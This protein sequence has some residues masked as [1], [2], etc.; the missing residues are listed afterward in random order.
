[1]TVPERSR[2]V[3]FRKVFGKVSFM[4]QRTE[5]GDSKGPKPGGRRLHAA[6]TAAKV[7]TVTEPGR[8]FDGQGLFLLVE[9][10]GAKRWKQRLT[11]QGRRQELGLGPY[12]VVTLAMARE[13]AIQ[14]RRDV[15]AGENP[16]TQRLRERDVPTFAEA[17]RKVF[18]LR[19]G[20]WKNA[21]H[22]EQWITTLEQFV[23]PR[24]GARG[25]D[26]VSTE[27][28]L[29]VLSP[30]WHTKPTTAKRVRQ[31]IAAVLTW[32]VAQGM[33][34]DNPADAVKAVL[35][36][37][38]NASKAQ[39]SLPYTEVASA[40]TTVQASQAAPALK[41]AFEFLVLTAA[42]AGEVRFATWGEIDCDARTWTVPAERMKAGREHRVPLSDRAIAV[43]DGARTLRPGRGE[44][45]FPSRGGR[46]LTEGGFVQALSRLGIDATAHGFR[47]SFRIWAQERTNIPR[48]V[49]EAALAHTVKDKAEAAY[50]RSD[51]FDKRR[52]LMDAWA[53]YLNPE[54]A[55]VLSLD[56]R[57]AIG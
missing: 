52:K 26:D 20:G 49:C 57:Q 18:D 11:V 19:R 48:E 47:S 27:D 55:A 15:R 50:A 38:A 13:A 5:N 56:S 32:A 54:P 17:A 25:V 29:A 12:P 37:H 30:I 39:R 7:R 6:L 2:R 10:T 31:R 41:L 23:F 51:L 46:P 9:P 42:R 28:V 3:L 34:P 33:R 16:K 1:M 14:H 22:A 21:K 45:V 4:E 24:L 43:L 44:L 53:T 35:A 8:Y 40:I 36:R